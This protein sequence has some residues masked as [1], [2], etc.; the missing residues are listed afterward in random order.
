[1]FMKLIGNNKM[2]PLTIL[3]HVFVSEKNPNMLKCQSYI[4]A[5]LVNNCL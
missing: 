1:M 5:T 2:P 4:K 3:C